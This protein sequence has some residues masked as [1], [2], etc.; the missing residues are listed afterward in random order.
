MRQIS[1][2]SVSTGLTTGSTTRRQAS[3]KRITAIYQLTTT[4][5]TRNLYFMKAYTSHLFTCMHGN[6]SARMLSLYSWCYNVL[7]ST[8]FSTVIL[9]TSV[10]RY[11][12][13]NAL[14]FFLPFCWQL[15]KQLAFAATQLLSTV[16]LLAL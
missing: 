3:F 2:I 4:S 5:C 10:L 6:L 15:L 16:L 9:P 8:P 13:H 1:C 7:L 12:L 11:S 14:R